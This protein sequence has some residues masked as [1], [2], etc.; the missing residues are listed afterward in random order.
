MGVNQRE[1]SRGGESFSQK[2]KKGGGQPFTTG[3]EGNG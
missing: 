3:G 1:E 2:E